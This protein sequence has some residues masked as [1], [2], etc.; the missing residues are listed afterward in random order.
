MK[1]TKEGK[2]KKGRFHLPPPP[3]SLLIITP[4]YCL[5]KNV[6]FVNIYKHKNKHIC[7]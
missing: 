2:E 5:L 3:G 7:K 1:R 6:Y 4:N